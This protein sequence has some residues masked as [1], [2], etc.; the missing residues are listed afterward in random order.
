MG[1]ALFNHASYL[2]D[3]YTGLKS[4]HLA[5]KKILNPIVL[6]IILR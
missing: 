2:V 3:T 1:M 4:S 6:C 5:G